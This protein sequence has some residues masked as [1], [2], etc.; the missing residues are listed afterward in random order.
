MFLFYRKIRSS[1]ENNHRYV[2]LVFYHPFHYSGHGQLFVW[3]QQIITCAQLFILS[4]V[5]KFL[6]NFNFDLHFC[7]RF[8]IVQMARQLYVAS[9]LDASRK[10]HLQYVFNALRDSIRF[11]YVTPATVKLC[12]IPN[13]KKTSVPIFLLFSIISLIFRLTTFVVTW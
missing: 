8:W 11:N 6:G 13:G 1:A 3:W 7:D 10:T 4:Y 9:F 12:N 2:D 5:S